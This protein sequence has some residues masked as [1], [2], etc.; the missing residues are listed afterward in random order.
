MTISVPN[1]LF[2]FSRPQLTLKIGIITLSPKFVF[3]SCILVMNTFF[4]SC[5]LYFCEMC[6]EHI[7][8]LLVSCIICTLQQHCNVFLFIYNSSDSVIE[9]AHQNLQ[10]TRQNKQTYFLNNTC[11]FGSD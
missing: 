7:F 3:Q 4:F 2:K 6:I 8:H 1:M 9:K 10:K 11:L 5:L